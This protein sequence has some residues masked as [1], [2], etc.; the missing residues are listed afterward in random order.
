MKKRRLS[1]IVS[2]VQCMLLPLS[3][4]ATKEYT[5][6][7]GNSI[8]ISCNMSAVNCNTHLAETKPASTVGAQHTTD[9]IINAVSFSS[10]LSWGS[11]IMAQVTAATTELNNIFGQLLPSLSA[12]AQTQAMGKRTSSPTGGENKRHKQARRAGHRGHRKNVETDELVSLMAKIIIS[13]E[14]QLGLGRLDRAF[15]LFMEQTGQVGV[16]TNLY[17]ASLV[18]HQKREEKQP[19]QHLQPL[20]TTLLSLMMM[21]LISR[22]NTLKDAKDDRMVCQKQGWMDEQGN[23]TFQVWDPT[24][25]ALVTSATQEPIGVQVIIKD[26]EDILGLINPDHILKF[27]AQAWR[28][29]KTKRSSTWRS[30]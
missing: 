20:R 4:S 7:H 23:L 18:W 2:S 25:K 3:S 19:S 16:L 9:T 8:S 13:H 14:D 1:P 22:L 28:K 15:T 21:E 24:K 30:A 29:Q 26:L 5:R 10:L 6:T 12:N 11:I 27:H 17:Q